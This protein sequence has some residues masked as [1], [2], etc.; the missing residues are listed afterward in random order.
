[1]I[2]TDV[3]RGISGCVIVPPFDQLALVCKVH[4]YRGHP[5]SLLEDSNGLMMTH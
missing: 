4:V 1:M 2:D 5:S 3:V